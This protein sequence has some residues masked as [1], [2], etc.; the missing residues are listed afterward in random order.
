MTSLKFPRMFS[1]ALAVVLFVC[2]LAPARGTAQT[3]GQ[4]AREAA[5][6]VVRDSE[7]PGPAGSGAE[8]PAAPQTLGDEELAELSERAEDPGEEVV[9]GALSNEH[10]T[11]IVIALAA[12]V[13]V[14]IV[15]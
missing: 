3:T 9:G 15:K 13:I 2:L 7:E 11:Y 6:E 1:K 10:L 12:A 4:P 8:A 14:L 5:A